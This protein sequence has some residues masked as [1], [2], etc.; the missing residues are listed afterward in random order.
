MTEKPLIEVIRMLPEHRHFIVKSF[1][2]GARFAPEFA[3]MDDDTY[4]Q[5]MTPHVISIVDSTSTLCAVDAE[6]NNVIIGFLTHSNE[7]GHFAYVRKD[8]RGEQIFKTL[9]S[10]AGI[11][12][13]SHRSGSWHHQRG[14][15]R[16]SPFFLPAG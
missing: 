5:W 6:D 16:W 12:A 9:R 4:Y 10:V 7:T 8:W 2:K 14:S 1:T 3:N 15:L 13:Y 11:S